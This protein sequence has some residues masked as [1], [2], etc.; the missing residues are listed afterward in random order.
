MPV[1]SLP[2]IVQDLPDT[3]FGDA[4][5][6]SQCGYRLTFLVSRRI[7]ALRAHLGEVLSETGN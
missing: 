3:L 5:D 7:S 1:T 2:E 6:F 4:K